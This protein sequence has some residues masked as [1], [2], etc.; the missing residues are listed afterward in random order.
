MPTFMAGERAILEI[1][2]RQGSGA[3]V[4]A[5]QAV[6]RTLRSMYLHA[7]QSYVWN[8]AASARVEQHGVGSVVA[9][10]LVLLL[11]PGGGG[12]GGGAADA[13]GSAEAA[14]AAAVAAE[15]ASELLAAAAAVDD[16]PGGE[17]DGSSAAARLA[18]VHRVTA[19]EAAA[20]KFS[21]ADV[22]L[23]VPGSQVLYPHYSAGWPLYCRL[24]AADGIVL[25]GMTDAEY[26]AAAAAA[27]AAGGGGEAAFSSTQPAGAT[28]A[29]GAGSDSQGTPLQ[30]SIK[31]FQLAG[32]T[33]DYRRLLHFPALQHRCCCVCVVAQLGCTSPAVARLP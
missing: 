14:A 17:L 33:G 28:A 13:G 19:E 22:V 9:G 12:G 21:I 29:A 31:E 15:D 24:A 11:P 8:Q 32:L 27:A 2:A 6:P 1:L 26:A 5:L 20:C 23:P 7:W 16:T 10:D 18:A 3:W 30:H 25:P 4:A